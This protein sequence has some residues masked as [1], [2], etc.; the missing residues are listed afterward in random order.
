METYVF[1]RSQLKKF[2]PSE[3][4]VQKKVWTEITRIKGK[5]A[6][7][8]VAKQFSLDLVFHLFLFYFYLFYV[9][10]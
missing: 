5:Y 7:M 1:F 2:M 10:F 3:V 8:S 4:E 6:E 9:F